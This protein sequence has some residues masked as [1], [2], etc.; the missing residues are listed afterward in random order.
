MGMSQPQP[1][2]AH[3]LYSGSLWQRRYNSTRWLSITGWYN[4]IASFE[5]H[6]PG[7]FDRPHPC[8]VMQGKSR[9]PIP[10]RKF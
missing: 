1:G 10:T 4:K 6:S 2:A 3:T 7:S 5:S 8:E 9:L